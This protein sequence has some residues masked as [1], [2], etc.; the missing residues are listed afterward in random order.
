MKWVPKRTWFGEVKGPDES[1]HGGY[2]KGVHN[3]I[4]DV[5]NCEHRAYISST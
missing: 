1:Q 5:D 4:K 2:E 3:L